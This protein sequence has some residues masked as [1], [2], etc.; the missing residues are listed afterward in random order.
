MAKV[1]GKAILFGEHFV[2]YGG[3]AIVSSIPLSLEISFKKVSSSNQSSILLNGEPFHNPA[4]DKIIA[5]IFEL[6][7]IKNSFTISVTSEIPLASG[8]GSSSAFIV[9]LLKSLNEYYN[10]GMELSEINS[11]AFSVERE[12]SSIISGIDNTIITYGGM[13]LFQQGNHQALHLKKPLS[14]L[15][16]NTGIQ[17]FTADVL[18]KTRN[19]IKSDAPMF[20]HLVDQCNMIVNKAFNAVVNGDLRCIGY[21][22]TENHALLK[23]LDVSHPRIEEII[24]LACSRGAYGGKVT[25]AGCGG[26]VIIAAEDYQPIITCLTDYGYNSKLITI[27][28]KRLGVVL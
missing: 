24:S 15:L 5:S 7:S 25:G 21:L 22:M 12:I 27:D 2:A 6:L 19:F 16:V 14:F 4:S 8:L 17:S 10:L 23:Q 3:K 13:M 1:Y 9:C 11:K 26:Y 18:K 20:N 28:G